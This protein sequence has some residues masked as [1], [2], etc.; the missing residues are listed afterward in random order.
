MTHA[1]IACHTVTETVQTTVFNDYSYKQLTANKNVADLAC[2][3]QK[4]NAVHLLHINV[5]LLDIRVKFRI[6]PFDNWYRSI[7]GTVRYKVCGSNF[8]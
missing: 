7:I 3:D 4:L 1:N 2:I 6:L 8:V 5:K